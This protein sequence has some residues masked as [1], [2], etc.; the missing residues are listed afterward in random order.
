MAS[1]E[2]RAKCE[3]GEGAGQYRSELGTA[4]SPDVFAAAQAGRTADASDIEPFW[5]CTRPGGAVIERYVP[6]LPLSRE[7]Q[8]HQRLLRTVGAYRMVIGQP[9]QDD[10]VRYVGEDAEWLRVDLTPR[11][12]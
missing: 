2:R 5:V 3:P 7:T 6:A 10:L 8:Q 12:V 9:R 4:P 11:P 1:I